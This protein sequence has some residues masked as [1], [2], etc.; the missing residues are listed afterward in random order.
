MFNQIFVPYLVEKNIITAAQAQEVL[1]IQKN[2]RIRIGVLA[3]EENLMTAS[4]VNEV[5]N[6]QAT[7]NKRFGDIAI[8]KGYLSKE[9][10]E[11]LLGKQPREHIILKQILGD[12]QYLDADEVDKYLRDFKVSLGVRDEVF[13]KLQDNDVDTFV[14]YIA[15]MDNEDIIMQTFARLFINTIIRLVDREVTVDEVYPAKLDLVK[16]LV[17]QNTIGDARVTFAYSAADTITAK[18]LAEGFAKF[19]FDEFDEDAQDSMQ[20]FLNCV[21]GL[22]ISELANN[23]IMDLDLEPPLYYDEFSVDCDTIVLPLSISVGALN[24]FIIVH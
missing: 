11:S 8:E 17:K 4:Q 18:G 1:E 9:Q 22:V 21:S 12:K 19:G 24:I 13:E 23:G 5:N 2:T 15:L 14:T 20:E 7:Q 3:E 6:L 16:V 10:L